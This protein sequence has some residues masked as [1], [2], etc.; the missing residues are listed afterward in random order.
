V[1]LAPPWPEIYVTDPERRHGFDEAVAEYARLQEVY[2]DLG[3]ESVVLPKIGVAGRADF[4][5]SSLD[6]R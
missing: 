6:R 2:A 3:Y 4:I 5:L 1:F